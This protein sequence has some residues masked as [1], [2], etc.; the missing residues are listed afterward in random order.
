MNLFLDEDFDP[1]F[2][3]ILSTIKSNE[4]YIN[5]AIAWYY[6]LALIKQYDQTIRL[7]ESKKLD[8]WIQNKS[9]QKAIES[10]RI[11]QGKKDYLRTLKIV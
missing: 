6:S 5:I 10:N 1:K 8:K 4:Y 7:I 2:L 11:E 9:I 3:D